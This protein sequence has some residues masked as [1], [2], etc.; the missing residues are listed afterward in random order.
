MSSLVFALRSLRRDL[1]AGELTVLLVAIIIAV[2]A[3]TAVGFFT[4]RV[5][6]A[7][8]SQA[9]AVMAGD[10]VLRSASPIERRWIERAEVLGLETAESIAFPTMVSTEEESALA[11]VRAVNPN[12]PLRGELIVST[13]MFGDTDRSEGVPEPGT[14]WAE[15]GLLG[16]MDIDVGAIIRVG[17]RDLRLTRILEYQP[18]RGMGGFS[19]M[20]PG[21]MVRLDDLDSLNVIK[22]GSRVTYRQLVA[23]EAP[24]V[25]EFRRDLEVLDGSGVTVRGLE[26]AGEQINA[27]IDRAQ[28]FLNLASL[29]TVILAAVATAMAARRYALRHLDTVALIK[30]I[31]ATQ[32]FIQNSTLIQL[33][34]VIAGTALVGSILGFAAQSVLVMLAAD[35][36]KV[37]LP[38]TSWT[39]GM[40]GMVTAATIAIGFALPHLLHLRTTAPLRVLRHD[41]PPPPLRAGATYGVALAA[42]LAMIYFI[43]RDLTLVVLIAGGI[44]VIAVAAVV[45]GWLLVRALTQFRGAAGVAW[46]YGLAS[47]SRRGAESVVQVVAFA[48]GLMV[49]LLLT[50][51]RN[52]LLGEWRR[53]IPSDAPNYFLINIEPDSWPQMA[54]FFRDEVGRVPDYLPFIRGRVTSINGTPTREL[55]FEDP[56]GANFLRQETN[57]TWRA[58]LPDTN[59]VRDGEWWDGGRRNEIELSLESGIARSLGVGVGDRMGFDVGG[60]K[61]EA[62]ITSLRA[63]EWDSMQ[64]N[65]YFML[66]P[67][68]SEELPQ[69]YIASI[70]VEQEKRRALNSVVRT[71]PGVTV[72]DLD[73]ILAQV[74][75]VIDRASM[76]VQ[77]VFLFTLMAG[78]VV[79]L[80]AIQITRDERRFESAILHTLGANRRTIFQGLAVEFTALG[81]LSGTLAAMGA[82]GV[83]W[84]L[85]S[86]IFDLDYVIDPA[87]WI[88]GLV[89]G[90]AIVGIA[91]T[92]ATRKAVTEPPVTVLRDS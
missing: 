48:L 22:P 40:L 72:L 59:T 76:S 17:D 12:Y 28:R 33:L 67:G 83:A 8:R 36:L 85:A 70:F 86:R 80:A 9:G 29:V 54:Q 35:I 65:F 84:V 53:T 3:M 60:E 41:L 38:P 78:I 55:S 49:L 66:S 68:L 4:D 58:R 74:R 14:V 82:S 63:V 5:G 19:G 69:T 51:V 50:L 1:R 57:M 15:P 44:A 32:R 7:V 90:S 73:V 21:L 92:L 11:F 6:R 13:E 81:A 61:F 77:Y 37:D 31:G 62:R 88:V 64:P 10:L 75:M 89:A 45:T 16:R 39:A 26:D 87:L 34:C 30:S 2:T 56:R 91:G 52:D 71:F 24:S 20:A 47:I 43:V 25:A 18:D 27:A 79:L 42:L 46:R 23:G